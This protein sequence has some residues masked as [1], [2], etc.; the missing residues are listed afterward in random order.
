MLVLTRENAEDNYTEIGYDIVVD[1]TA[2]GAVNMIISDDAYLERIDV[3]GEYRGKGY[4]TAAI[5]ELKALYRGLDLYAAPDNEGSRRLFE[6]IG[7][8]YNGKNAEYVDQ[9]FG[10]YE[11]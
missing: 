2:V 4:G 6:R 11:I 8:P 9:G 7:S 3:D 5:K 10:V 1:G